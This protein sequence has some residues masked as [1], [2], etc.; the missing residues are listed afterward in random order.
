LSGTRYLLESTGDRTDR[1]AEIEEMLRTYGACVLGAGEF[2][3]RGVTMPDHTTLMG[4]GTATRLYLDPAVEEGFAVRINSFCTVKDMAI[5]GAYEDIPTPKAVGTRHGLLFEGTAT[6]KD[7]V[8]TCRRNSI[9]S[10]CLVRYFSGG[11]ITCKDTGYMIYA[12]RTASNCHLLNCGAGINVTHFS[13]YHEFTNMLCNSNLY[14]CIN[15]G[16]NNVF[17][18]CGFN[19]NETGFLMDNR[20]GQSP[21][22]SHGTVSACTFNHNGNNEGI[23]IQALGTKNGYVFTGCQ[24]FFSKIVLE[25][26]ED[27]A[28]NSFNCGRK[29]SISVKGGKLVMFTGCMFGHEPTI[30]VE[31]NDLVKFINCYTREGEV[32]SAK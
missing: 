14:G 15:N 5:Y 22:N 30:T 4:L 11:G 20:E 31:D 23:G 19:D 32:I 29:V 10:G 17:V 16:G 9:V 24:L 8:D 1:T 12:A 6:P 7:Y 28:F 21:N 13:E 26:C 27:F 18:N 3:V 2:T 25:D